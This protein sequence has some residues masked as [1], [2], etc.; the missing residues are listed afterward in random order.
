M[1]RTSP[2]SHAPSSLTHTHWHYGRVAI[3]LHWV[4]AILLAGMAGLGWYMLANED[5]PGMQW[6][7]DLHR[8]IGMVIALLIVIRVLWRLA[9]RPQAL[10]ASVPAW[11]ARLAAGAQVL[12]YLLIT[13]MVVTGYLGAS[14][15]RSGVSIFGWPTPHWAVPNREWAHQLF[16]IHSALIWVLV[17]VVSVHALGALK[18]LLMDKDGVFQRMWFARRR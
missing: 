2:P 12:L 7:F 1:M 18:H 4:M 3:I 6:Y 16:D 14:Y 5:E 9:H 15:T 13:A 8:S 17:A 11:Q 10:P